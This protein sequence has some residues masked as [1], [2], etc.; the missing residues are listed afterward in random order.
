MLHMYKLGTHDQWDA[1][2][3]SLDGTAILDAS[4]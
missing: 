1:E 3:S 2:Q 4:W